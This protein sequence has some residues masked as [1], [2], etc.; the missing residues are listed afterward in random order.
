MPNVDLDF[1]VVRNDRSILRLGFRLGLSGEE[2]ALAVFAE[3]DRAA[4]EPIAFSKRRRFFGSKLFWS[5]A[6]IDEIEADGRGLGGIV[7]AVAQ[8]CEIARLVESELLIAAHALHHFRR[9]AV[10]QV[11]NNERIALAG[12]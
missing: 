11:E 4:R 3:S 8:E 5:L 2:D 1:L 6:A 9:L 10:G 12:L 7:V